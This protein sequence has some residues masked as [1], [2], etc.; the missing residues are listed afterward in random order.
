MRKKCD[1]PDV[2]VI[3]VSLKVFVDQSEHKE[4]RWVQPSGDIRERLEW[5]R[6]EEAADKLFASQTTCAEDWGAIVGVRKDMLGGIY[7]LGL[8]KVFV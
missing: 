2:V 5:Q 8:G 3:Y 6:M 7:D 1:S 4:R